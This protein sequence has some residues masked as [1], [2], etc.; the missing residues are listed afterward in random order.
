MDFKVKK[1]FKM[2]Y[3]THHDSQIVEVLRCW[4]GRRESDP[5]L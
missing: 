2:F 3:R 1:H 4:D 5:V